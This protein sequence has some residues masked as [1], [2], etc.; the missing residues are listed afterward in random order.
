M[1]KARMHRLQLVGVNLDGRIPDAQQR[2]V[3]DAFAFPQPIQPGPA[4]GIDEGL[5]DAGIVGPILVHA[6]QRGL[7]QHHRRGL[8]FPEQLLGLGIAE[9]VQVLDLNDVQSALGRAGVVGFDRPHR[10]QPVADPHGLADFGDL[11]CTIGHGVNLAFAGCQ[12]R[13]SVILPILTRRSAL[14]SRGLHR[15]NPLLNSSGCFCLISLDGTG[16]RP[17]GG[18]RSDMWHC[19]GEPNAY[20][21]KNLILPPQWANHNKHRGN[22]L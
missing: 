22:K 16:S 1:G 14:R 3:L 8:D 6:G 15:C 13:P 4:V 20:F 12:V 2:L 19:Q 17:G 18:I 5:K 21:S 9:V 10:R 7:A 11:Y